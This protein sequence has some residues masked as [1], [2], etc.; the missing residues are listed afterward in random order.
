MNL[1]SKLS[2]SRITTYYIVAL[3]FFVFFSLLP[4][5]AL[6]QSPLNINTQEGVENNIH[7]YS[8]IAM[9]EVLRSASCFLTGKDPLAVKA[10][11]IGVNPISGKYGYINQENN[12]MIGVMG[13]LMSMTFNIPISTGQYSSYLANDFGI[14]KKT[15][16]Q[17]PGFPGLAPVLN[18]WKTFRNISYLLFVL[19]FIALGLGIMFRVKVD[20][21]TVMTVQNQ[22]PKIIIALVLV[23][24]SYAIVGF[25]IDLMFG[26][27]YLEFNIIGSSTPDIQTNI[28]SFVNNTIDLEGGGIF[29]TMMLSS[30][31]VGK[32]IASSFNNLF[33]ELGSSLLG[34]ATKAIGV[35]LIPVTFGAS[36]IPAGCDI[37]GKIG[38]GPVSIRDIPFISSGCDAVDNLPQIIIGAITTILAFLVIAIAVLWAL[39]RTWFMLI[40]AFVYILIDTLFAPLWIS[41]G[42]LPGA[43][44]L[45]F[46]KWIR[47][48]MAN[49]SVFPVVVGMY[50]IANSLIHSFGGANSFTPPLVGNPSQSDAIGALIAL[51]F[52]LS[53][54]QA[55]STTRNAF[56]APD[57]KLVALKTAL[58]VGVGGP[59]RVVS[60]GLGYVYSPKH[61][62]K[63]GTVIYPAGP[64]GKGLRALGIIR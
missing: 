39:F 34:T 45:G 11:C 20:P 26:F 36:G 28:F 10:Q 4:S 21:R 3:L 14:A 44:G 1:L 24:L 12:G 51:G 54:P 40:R 57:F 16:A 52:I 25:L 2:L 18:L 22:I 23:S 53:T 9:I 56:K 31:S 58:G 8:Q 13:N 27:I 46:E 15:Y 50:L 5:Q 49:I 41:V 30:L 29:G 35:L 48:L 47:H 43:S 37:A 7:T 62:P 17:G 38:I 33:A 61:D 63:S 6:A 32:I 64:I 60:G 42:I 59:R 19:I 55:I